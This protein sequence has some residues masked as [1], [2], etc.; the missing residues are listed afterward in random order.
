MADKAD[1]GQIENLR[2]SISGLHEQLKYAQSLSIVMDSL[3][4]SSP[5]GAVLAETLQMHKV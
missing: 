4:K 5:D 3:E 1:K 2:N